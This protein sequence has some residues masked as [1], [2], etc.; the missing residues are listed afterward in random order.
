MCC[1][2]KVHVMGLPGIAKEQMVKVNQI[3]VEELGI[4]VEFMMEH[5]GINLTHY[6]VKH[7]NSDYIIV[8]AG[9][10]NNGGSGLVA[11]RRL[12]NWGLDVSV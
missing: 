3:M 12:V 4:P 10:G 5:A 1:V 7:C 2:F 11:A 9:S 6:I 8:V